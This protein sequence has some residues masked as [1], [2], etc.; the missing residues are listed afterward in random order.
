M[1]A[2]SLRRDAKRPF[3]VSEFNQPFPNPRGAEIL[4]LMSAVGALQDLSLI[5]I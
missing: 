2:L 3:V 5:H 4:P 1:L